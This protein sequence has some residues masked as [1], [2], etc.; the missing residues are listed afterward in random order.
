MHEVIRSGLNRLLLWMGLGL[1]GLG[2]VAAVLFLVWWRSSG[3]EGLLVGGAVL[4]LVFAVFGLL[5]WLAGRRAKV[6]LEP[7]GLRWST[8]FSGSGAAAWVDVAQVVVPEQPREQGH[9]VLL[10]MRNGATVPVKALGMSSRRGMD[11]RT[12]SHYYPDGGYRKAGARLVAAHQE[13]LARHG[14]PGR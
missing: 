10:G 5:L 12:R 3:D 4:G 8:A 2:V 6:V 9:H 1:I 14:G 13:W 7:D 11:L